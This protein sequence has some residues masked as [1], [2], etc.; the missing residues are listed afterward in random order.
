MVQLQFLMDDIHYSRIRVIYNVHV[1]NGAIAIFNGR[2][3]LL[4]YS[5]Y[6]RVTSMCDR[7]RFA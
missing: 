2:Y 6:L 3:S 4:A 1:E 5:C 7:I